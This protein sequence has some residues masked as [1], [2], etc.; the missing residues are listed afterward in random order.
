ML[1]V[2]RTNAGVGIHQLHVRDCLQ[3][4]RIEPVTSSIL[5]TTGT[6]YTMAAIYEDR[7]LNI[8]YPFPFQERESIKC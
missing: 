5:V 6:I 7:V 2:Y 8:S 1:F 4:Q 3:I